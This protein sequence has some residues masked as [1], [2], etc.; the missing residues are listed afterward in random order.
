MTEHRITLLDAQKRQGL[1]SIFA[2]SSSAMWT[3]CSGSLIPNL[4]AHDSAGIEAATGTVAH[5]VAETW[6]RTGVRPNHLIGTVEIVE[7]P[8]ETFEIEID[9]SMLDYLQDYIDVVMYLPGVHFIETRVDFSDL[10]PIP[11]QS[12]TAD[13]GAIDRRTLTVTDLKFGEGIEVYAKNNTQAIIYA[14]GFFKK[15]DDL[16]DFDKIV[17][18]ISQPRRNHFDEW[19]I[20]REELLEWAAWIK[21]R[22]YDAWC[23]DG[24]RKPAVKTCQWCKIKPDCTAYTVFAERILDNVFLDESTITEAD[25]GELQARLDKDDYELWPRPVGMLTLEQ[26][27][28]LL[29][30]QGMIESWF[31]QIKADLYAHINDG[32]VVPGYKI[33]EG[34]SKRSFAKPAELLDLFERLHLPRS[35][36]YKPQELLSPPMVEDVLIKSGRKRK[37]LPEILDPIVTRTPG[38]PTL[39]LESDTRPSLRDVAAESFGNEDEL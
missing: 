22:A 9:E 29:P 4:Y 27:A 25:M 30:Y 21:Q 32:K 26:K 10:T 23:L 14:Y 34:R 31:K 11:N 36:A 2:P 35:L 19:T 28:R 16:F 6:L 17:I 24:E 1:H 3:G 39:A 38:K 20:T 7:E 37:E 8:D 5:G 15:Y 12:G 33:V 13:H 18:R